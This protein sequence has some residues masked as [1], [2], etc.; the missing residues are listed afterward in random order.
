MKSIVY[1]TLIAFICIVCYTQLVSAPV[2]M[3]TYNPW[4]QRLQYLQ[5][6][7]QTGFN[8]TA[9]YFKGQP[10]IGSL[11]SG[12]I[13]AE[14]LDSNANL[15]LT[16]IE[17]T[18]DIT[19]KSV[20]VMLVDT[21]NNV[22]YCTIPGDTVTTTD[23]QHS[24][25]YVSTDCSVQSTTIDNYITTDLSPGGITELFNSM[26]HSGAV[27]VHQG[28]P[29][30]NKINIKNRKATFSVAHLRVISGMSL[31]EELWK[32]FTI[33]SGE[34]IYINDVVTPT[35]QNLTNN[36]TLEIFYHSGG[37]WNYDEY[38][39]T[40]QTGLNLTSC[41]D[42]SGP[43]TCS[44]PS[45][46]RRY[47]LFMTGF[48][49][50]DDE[51]K[52]HQSLAS[53]DITYVSIGDCLN[54]EANPLTYLVPDIYT[55]TIVPLY[56]YCG[57]ASDTAWGGTFIDLRTATA[58]TTSGGIDTSIFL[59]KDG[60]RPL[61]ANWNAGNFNISASFRWN[62]LTD[63]PVSCPIGTHIVQLGDSI[64]C[65]VPNA[66]NLTNYAQALIENFNQSLELNID[67]NKVLWMP[68]EAGSQTR[69][70][71]GYQKLHHHRCDCC[72]TGRALQLCGLECW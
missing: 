35:T 16:H 14:E 39:G 62:N 69:D 45:K 71:S 22:K 3:S 8:W 40:T 58:T 2:H 26:A 23:N 30:Q 11:D 18:L 66:L 25:Y 24:V 60:T 46:Y 29:I 41:D 21:M 53:E 42:G 57:R 65:S 59:T 44:V 68:F 20:V 12:I 31:S 49:D 54:T 5:S 13:W 72:R 32:N 51:T 17:G 55:Y 47:F 48:S 70:H 6:P 19:Y 1:Y 4:T 33:S 52:I 27:E 63:Y 36:A 67:S 43:V 56:A 9:D 28:A 15:N 7:N 37:D 38:V 34:Y 10:M 64:T 61:T 50:G